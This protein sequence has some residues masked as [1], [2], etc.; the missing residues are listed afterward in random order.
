MTS[1]DEG[2][3]GLTVIQTIDLSSKAAATTLPAGAVYGLLAPVPAP[4]RGTSVP[5]AVSTIT[6][7]GTTNVHSTDMGAVALVERA[8]D[9]S[10]SGIVGGFDTGVELKKRNGVNRGRPPREPLKGL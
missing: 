4:L 9:G 2:R 5:S 7:E 10:T 8:W 1:T 3:E 6:V